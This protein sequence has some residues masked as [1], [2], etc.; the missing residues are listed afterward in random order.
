MNK[1]ANL[2]RMLDGGV[3][4]IVRLDSAGQLGQ[5]ARAIKAGGA[6]V[7]EFTMTTPGALDIIAASTQEFG[8][9]VL[10][11]AGTVLDSE[12]ARAAIL[13][14]ARFIVSPTL[15]PATVELCHRYSV[16]AV[17]GTFT[18]TEILTAWE[19]GADLVKVFPASAG[20]PGYI[21][22]VLAPLPQVRLVP[23]GGVNVQNAA[24]YIQAGAAA[25]AVGGSLVNRKLVAAGDFN[26]LTETA[27][28]LVAAVRQA[29][30]Q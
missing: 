1:E 25:V 28:G 23:T 15:N 9:Q 7:I 26:T 21:K 24:D 16:I 27:R 4:A 13:A 17:P 20:G 2:K 19:S 22:A 3:I 6:D 12:T 10:L 18:P 8:D 14:G 30:G 5:V 11:G 29:R